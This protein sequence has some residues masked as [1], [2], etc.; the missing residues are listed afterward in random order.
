MAFRLIPREEKFFDDFAEMAGAI[1]KGATLLAEMLEPERPIWEKSQAIKTVEHRC[2]EISHD[3]LTR[4]HRTFV[5]PIDREDIHALLGALDD[6]I[7]DIDASAD[8]LRLYRIETVRPAARELSRHIVEACNEML[9]GVEALARGK[10]VT[11]AVRE[12][13]QIENKADGAYTTGVG[14]L[15]EQEKDPIQVI[16]WKE[17]LDM[18]E[19]AT[20]R[21]KDV[22]KVLEAI[23]V[24]HN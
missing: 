18:L 7:D 21:C 17:I 16:K 4:L 15:F 11:E 13:S 22:A 6:V 1:Q 23:Y 9:R 5:T 12:I 10:G 3:V 2:D 24:K 8:M 19:G 14:T 20:D